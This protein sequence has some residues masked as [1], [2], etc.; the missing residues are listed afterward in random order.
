MNIIHI[1]ATPVER[2]IFKK[3]ERNEKVMGILLDMFKK[4]E[5]G[6]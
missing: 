5:T 1:T 4:Q 6:V 2:R 3:L